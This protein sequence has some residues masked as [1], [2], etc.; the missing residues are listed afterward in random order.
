C[1]GLDPV[2]REYFLQF[3]HRQA[4]IKNGP[5]LVF[6]THHVEE[7]LPIFSHVLLLKNGQILAAGKK[8]STLTSKN[9]SA[10]FAA[11]VRLTKVAGRYQLNAVEKIRIGNRLKNKSP[12]RF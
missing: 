3:I 7:I 9:F 6:V 8:N 10:A 5:T 11:Q 1:A 2:A 4:R 12:F